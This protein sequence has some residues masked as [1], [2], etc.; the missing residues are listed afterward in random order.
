M[1]SKLIL[2]G[3]VFLSGIA[4]SQVDANKWSLEFGSGINKAYRFQGESSGL[5]FPQFNLGIRYMPNTYFGLRLAGSFD[6]FKSKTDAVDSLE[7]NTNYIGT[8]LEGV[9]NLGRLLHFE[10]WTNRLGVLVHTGPGVG[11]ISSPLLDKKETVL[12]AAMGI[13]ALVRLNDRISL[14]ADM[15]NRLNIRQKNSLDMLTT[16]S[17]P[18]GFDSGFMNWSLG[19]VI[20]LGKKEK[21]MDWAIPENPYKAEMEAQR[22][23]IEI[24]QEKIVMLDKEVLNTQSELGDDDND[25][26]INKMDEEPNT[27]KDAVVDTK[28]REMK[29]LIP[30]SLDWING[31]FFTVQLGVYSREIPLLIFRQLTPISTK[32]ME[33][34][35]I[36]YFSGIYHSV[37]EAKTQHTNALVS[38]VS[39]AFITAY[40]NGSRITI[41]EAELILKTKGPSILAPKSN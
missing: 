33:D 7:F 16:N 41:A 28:G 39:D 40:Y 6:N 10:D 25:G 14:S 38:G 17:N 29:N 32:R 13:T 1:K 12:H 21:H 8:S 27:P 15:T 19:A 37:E 4:Y 18:R 24:L 20:S 36:R 23:S 2:W 5:N 3:A 31:L 34:N 30:G 11:F 9:V 35:T 22:K 26:V